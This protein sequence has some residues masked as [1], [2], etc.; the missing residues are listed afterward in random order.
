MERHIWHHD[1]GHQHIREVA[2][3]CHCGQ[4]GGGGQDQGMVGG[5]DS[6][7][8]ITSI[9]CQTADAG[10]SDNRGQGYRQNQDCLHSLCFWHPPD[11]S[12]QEETENVSASDTCSGKDIWLHCQER[13]YQTAGGTH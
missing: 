1:R 4:E 9:K 13:R 12:D 10:K 5:A 11:V 8:W 6:E 2:K 7:S 3:R